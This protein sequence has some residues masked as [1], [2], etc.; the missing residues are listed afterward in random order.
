MKSESASTAYGSK[1]NILFP[2]TA[3]AANAVEVESAARQND[4]Q[5]TETIDSADVTVTGNGELL[6]YNQAPSDKTP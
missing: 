4:L 2:G 6:N 3:T 5:D 1:D